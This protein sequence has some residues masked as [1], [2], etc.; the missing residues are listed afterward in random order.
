MTQETQTTGRLWEQRPRL[1]PYPY[2]DDPAELWLDCVSYFEWAADNAVLTIDV[3]KYQ[4]EALV[5]DIPH[6]RPMTQMGLCVFLGITHPT[7]QSWRRREEV[8]ADVVATVD[9]VIFEQKFTGAAVGLFNP[10]LIARELGLM[11]KEPEDPLLFPPEELPLIT[12]DMSPS[13][14]ADIYARCLVAT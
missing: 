6:P 14:A 12:R 10:A 4:G 8:F 13:E 9:A 1:G 11:T 5:I 3:V 2:Y 7:W